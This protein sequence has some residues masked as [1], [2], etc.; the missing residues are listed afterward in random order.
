[1][2]DRHVAEILKNEREKICIALRDYRGHRFIDVRLYTAS[3][4]EFF[5]T[6]KGIS[7]RP[8]LLR[9]LIEALEAAKVAAI[10]EGLIR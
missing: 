1:M 9:S 10:E 4:A 5:P 6:P 2:S 7:I 3:G 8:D